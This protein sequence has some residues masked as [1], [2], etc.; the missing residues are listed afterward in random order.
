MPLQCMMEGLGVAFQEHQPQFSANSG[1]KSEVY[2]QVEK[3]C[4]PFMQID[5]TNQYFH[6]INHVHKDAFY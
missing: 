5:V 4:P 1:H 3:Y 2:A 6:V